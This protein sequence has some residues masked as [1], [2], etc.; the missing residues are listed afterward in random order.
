MRTRQETGENA[1]V[2]G[3]GDRTGSESFGKAQTIFRQGIERRS[4]NL[5]VTVA[6]NVIGAERVDSDKKDIWS[7]FRECGGTG[8]NQRLQ[9]EADGNEGS[10]KI[11]L[12]PSD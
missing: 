3:I 9:A 10:G 8:K 6:M 7:S 2:R 11:H 1:G 5:V 12:G 4:L